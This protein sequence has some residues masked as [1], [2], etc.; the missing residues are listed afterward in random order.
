MLDYTSSHIICD[1]PKLYHDALLYV[2]T[3][4]C[5]I[6]AALCK[7]VVVFHEML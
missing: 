5:C 2:I 6:Y 4:I 1:N 7:A 3:T